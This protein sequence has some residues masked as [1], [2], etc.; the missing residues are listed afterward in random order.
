VNA[1][2]PLRVAGYTHASLRCAGQADAD[3]CAVAIPANDVYR[4]S[5]QRRPLAHGLQPEVAGRDAPG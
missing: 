5:D 4:A 2:A 1:R 3:L